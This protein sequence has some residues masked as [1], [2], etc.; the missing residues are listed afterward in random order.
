M[1]VF[2]YDASFEG[3]LSAVFDAYTRREFPDALLSPADA[4][5]LLRTAA[6][7]VKTSEE[8]SDRVWRALKKKLSGEALEELRLAWLSEEKES[9]ALIFRYI[10]KV[11]DSL[12][13]ETD[14]AD[15]HVFAVHRLAKRVVCEKNRLTGFARFQKTRQ[16]VYFAAIAPRHNVLP[17]LLGHFA[18][19]FADQDWIVYDTQRFYGVLRSRGAFTQVCLS[20]ERAEALRSQGGRLEASL[21]EEG[22]ALFQALWRTYF[23][24]AA[25]IE[26]ENPRQQRRCMPARYWPYLTELQKE[27]AVVTRDCKVVG[28]LPQTP[29]G[30]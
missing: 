22:E 13:A 18:D 20:L 25:I 28:A 29:Q 7:T 14:L 11:F 16:G 15:A 30:D 19:R 2:Y 27:G 4:S 21:L 8:K 24:A 26:R 12:R 5:P 6:H 23:T 17:L 3:L 10:C 9:D 1:R